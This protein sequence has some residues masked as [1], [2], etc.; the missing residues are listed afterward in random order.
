MEGEGFKDLRRDALRNAGVWDMLAQCGFLKFMQVALMWN[1][2]LLLETLVGV[3]DV[4][5]E[6]FII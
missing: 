1:L 3:W 6:C 2:R 4:G 5:A